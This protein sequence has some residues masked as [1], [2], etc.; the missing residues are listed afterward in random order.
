MKF[1]VDS[2]LGRLARWLRLLGYDTLYYPDIEDSL[3]LR[4]AREDDRILLTR[5]THVIKVRGLKKYFLLNENKTFKQVKI[6]INSL[7]LKDFSIMSRC[8]ICNN[9]ITEIQKE[10]I[11]GLVPEY[12]YQTTA[13]F[14]RCSGCGKLYWNGTHPE[15]FKKKLSEIL[16]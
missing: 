3:L 5:D 11:R 9:T 2:M 15:K 6:V 16:A 7:N 13:V 4:I 14:K 10:G 1:I 8:V 12:V